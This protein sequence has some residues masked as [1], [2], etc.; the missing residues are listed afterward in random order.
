MPPDIKTEQFSQF[1][2]SS[3]IFG[4]IN[5]HDSEIKFQKTLSK[6]LLI[7][8]V[9]AVILIAVDLIKDRT[10]YDRMSMIEKEIYLN[11]K[12]SMGV[13]NLT[14]QDLKLLKECLKLGGWKSCFE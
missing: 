14:A 1:Q 11:E 7:G 3:L 12:N 2:S 9:G 4:K 5:E 10:L 13:N 6:I 8:I